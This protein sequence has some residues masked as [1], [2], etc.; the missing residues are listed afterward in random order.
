MFLVLE[1]GFTVAFLA[2]DGGGFKVTMQIF[3]FSTFIFEQCGSNFPA[4]LYFALELSDCF[5][6]ILLVFEVEI[7]RG[8]VGAGGGG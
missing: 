3:S 7:G 6:L 2:F 5:V 1:F 4:S 8:V